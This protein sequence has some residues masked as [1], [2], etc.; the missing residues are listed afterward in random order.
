M[1]AVGENGKGGT[2]APGPMQA[3]GENGKGGTTAPGPMQAVGENVFALSGIWRFNEES[4]DKLNDTR[5]EQ[6]QPALIIVECECE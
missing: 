1:Q 3:V 2:S 6:K 5:A 4:S